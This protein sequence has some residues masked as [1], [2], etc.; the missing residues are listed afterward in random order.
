MLDLG[1]DMTQ[2]VRNRKL[3]DHTAAD[4]PNTQKAFSGQ[5]AAPRHAGGLV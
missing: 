3:C 2:V 4:G 1:T 5:P